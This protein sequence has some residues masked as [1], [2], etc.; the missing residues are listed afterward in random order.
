M[1]QKTRWTA[2]MNRM[3][4]DENA[5][6]YEALI[7]LY[8]EKH[9]FYHNLTH[10]EAAL[11]HLEN[12]SELAQ[13]LSE[14]EIALWFHDAIYAPFSTTNELDSANLAVDFLTKNQV[15]KDIVNR[16]YQLIMATEHNVEL[17][18]S[19]EK[20]MVDIDLSILGCSAKHYEQ[21]ECN[22]RKEYK[23]V[24]Y[25]LYKKKRKEI[26]QSFLERERIYHHQYFFERL[27]QQARIN[28]KNAISLL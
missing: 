15:N 28:L 14:I 10:I 4:L 9:R 22:V 11:I 24:P 3:G 5:E 27:E 17:K 2:L 1:K 16:V 12:T 7:K 6:T 21:F 25:F 13:H 8:S 18:S 19:D 20:L 23:W 26:L